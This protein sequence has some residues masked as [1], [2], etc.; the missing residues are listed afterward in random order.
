MNEVFMTLKQGVTLVLLALLSLPSQLHAQPAP[1]EIDLKELDRQ[2]PAVSAKPEPKK[3]EKGK[4][5]PAR[6]A[7]TGKVPQTSADTSDYLRYTV[8]P[9][10]HIFKILMVRFG[11]SNEAAERLIPEIIRINYISNIKKLAVGRT[12]LIP[13]KGQ[14]EHAARSERKGSSQGRRDEVET[15]AMPEIAP[16]P[17]ARGAASSPRQEEAPVAPPSHTATMPTAPA[18]APAAQAI[19]PAITW[20]CSVTERDPARVVD[21]VLN[22]MSVSWSKNRIIESG[23]GAATAFSIRVDRYFEYKGVRYIVSIGESD[24]Y[25]YTLIRLL[26]AAGYRTLKIGAGEDFKIVSEKLLRLMGL[27]P[28]FGKHALQGGR[29]AKGFLVRQDDAGGRQVVITGD[30]VDQRTSWVLAPGCGAR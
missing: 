15:A 24:P 19:P 4:R 6:A 26:E 20:V 1:F 29:E 30:P 10:D 17:D 13:R 9:G 14:H 25:S 27:V 22:A 28:D 8:K 3:A 23:K 18:P 11:M 2:K 16:K 5:T 21:A 12:L 7:R